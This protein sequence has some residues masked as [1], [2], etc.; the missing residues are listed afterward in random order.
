MN[1]Y[2]QF[3]LSNLNNLQI[4][5]SALYLIAAPS[6]PEPVRNNVIART[7]D[8][9]AVTHGGVRA[10]VRQYQETGS[11]PDIHTD[12]KQLARVTQHPRQIEAPRRPDPEARERDHELKQSM[13]ATT[14]KLA[15]AAKIID[16]VTALVN[17]GI[18]FPQMLTAIPEIAP[19]GWSKQL[20]HALRYLERLSEEL[21]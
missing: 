15:A 10:L 5:V 2:V 16:A 7:Q 17:P 6:T 8:G 12:L 18:T 9:Q 3:K 1:V 20:P 4:D 11:V 19:V 13:Q 14:V 21:P